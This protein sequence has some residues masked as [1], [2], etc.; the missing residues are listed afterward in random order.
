MSKVYSDFLQGGV[1]WF[2]G[3]GLHR[4]DFY[5]VVRGVVEYNRDPQHRGRVMVR[6][7]EDGPEFKI[8]KEK[9][10]EPRKATFDLGWCSPMF[11]MGSGAGFG[12]FTVP[13]VGSRVYVMYERGNYQQPLYFGGWVANAP[14]RRRYGATKTTLEPPVKEAEG[15]PGYSEEG[16]FGEEY[17]LKYPPKPP[18]YQGWWEE[19]Q[20]P[21]I[22]LE[23]T[24]M[25]DH[26]PDS[27]LLFKT[28][29]GASLL[30]KERDEAEELILT[31]RLGAELRFSSNTPITENEVLRRGRASAT[32]HEP[33]TL[34]NLAFESHT[35]SLL[36]ASR[37]GLEVANTSDGADDSLHVQIH[38]EHP[39]TKN[40]ELMD[41]RIAVELDEGERRVRLIYKED[42][43]VTG[44]LEFDAVAKTINLEGLEHIHLDCDTDI[45]LTAPKV[46]ILG[47]LDV[48]GEIRHLG[49]EKFVFID[50]DME[51]YGSQFRNHWTHKLPNVPQPQHDPIAE[52]Q[53]NERRWW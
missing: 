16:E 31:D 24:E 20:G 47:D 34:D 15:D 10:S 6:V 3:T 39:Y 25:I 27:Q 49:G 23:L 33:I 35:M 44:Q 8:N 52:E 1:D 14:A 13:P 4:K 37:T 36:T 7:L 46:K 12:A 11:G 53:L 19:E 18:P 32:K 45:V 21:E 9:K 40:P 30:V 28:L 22:A 42:G 41:T 51:P 17:G 43:V 48:E 26:V 29:K 38:P 2:Y 50:N 5:A